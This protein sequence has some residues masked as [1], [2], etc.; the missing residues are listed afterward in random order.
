MSSMMLITVKTTQVQKIR[1]SLEGILK[2][3]CTGR[4]SKKAEL[5]FQE[6]KWKKKK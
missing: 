6:K 1:K 5:G 3:K 2:E 4:V